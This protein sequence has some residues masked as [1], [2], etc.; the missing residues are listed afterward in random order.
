[1]SSLEED[2]CRCSECALCIT[3]AAKSYVIVPKRPPLTYLSLGTSLKSDEKNNLEQ[4][5]CNF[6]LCSE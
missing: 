6:G 4:E 3:A 1:M 2:L 5:V